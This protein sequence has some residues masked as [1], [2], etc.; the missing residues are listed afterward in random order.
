MGRARALWVCVR[1]CVWDR[2]TS[3]CACVRA[4]DSSVEKQV[5]ELEGIDRTAAWTV[6]LQRWHTGSLMHTCTHTR[7]TSPP[8]SCHDRQLLWCLGTRGWGVMRGVEVRGGGGEGGWAQ[9]YMAHGTHGCQGH[10]DLRY[11]PTCKVWRGG[12][13]PLHIPF[14]HQVTHRL[15]A[16]FGRGP[17]A[18]LRW[19][20]NQTQS[21][22]VTWTLS[23]LHHTCYY[24]SWIKKNT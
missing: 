3:V 14:S 7:T 4:A 18:D 23:R 6:Q 22:W 1:A 13:Y 21:L 8:V 2:Q 17:S 11:T 19:Q 10:F 12:A 24:N 5:W 20:V 9:G 16:H 15:T